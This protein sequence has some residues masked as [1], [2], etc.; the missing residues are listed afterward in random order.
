M[1]VAFTATSTNSLPLAGVFL[2]VAGF[3]LTLVSV[4]SQSPSLAAVP[5][6]TGFASVPTVGV[7]GWGAVDGAGLA[8]VEL[9]GGVEPTVGVELTGGVEPTAGV[10]PPPLGALVEPPP[11]G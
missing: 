11:L 6:G 5:T 10:E 7:D 2:I 3:S 9:T 1:Y 4:I 8:G